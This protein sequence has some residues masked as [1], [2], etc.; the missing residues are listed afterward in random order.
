MTSSRKTSPSKQQ[1]LI[2]AAARLFKA[3]GYRATTLEDIASAVGMLKGSLY[4]YIRSKEELLQVLQ[5]KL[6][7]LV[8]VKVRQDKQEKWDLLLLLLLECVIHAVD[9]EK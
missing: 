6:V 3:N 4:Y 8:M 7:K 9:K 2:A 1:E 5:Q